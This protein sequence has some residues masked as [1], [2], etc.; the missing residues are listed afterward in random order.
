[1]VLEDYTIQSSWT[2]Q[3]LY[4]D[5]YGDQ[6]YWNYGLYT[7]CGED[8]LTKVTE[9]AGVKTV[10]VAEDNTDAPVQYFNLNGIRVNGDNLTPGLY[11]RRQGTKASKVI[12]R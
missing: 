1:M 5:W 12:I 10:T 7:G 8:I 9:D 6:S 3:G 11:I 2:G 4:V